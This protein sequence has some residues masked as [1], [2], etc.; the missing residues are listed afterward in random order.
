[1]SGPS[2]ETPLGS[3]RVRLGPHSPTTAFGG[4]IAGGFD[5]AFRL[6]NPSPAIGSGFPEFRYFHLADQ[7]R[8]RFATTGSRSGS[9]VSVGLRLRGHVA[10]ACYRPVRAGMCRLPAGHTFL[11]Q[12]IR[13]PPTNTEARGTAPAQMFAIRLRLLRISL[14]SPP[15]PLRLGLSWLSFSPPSDLP[16]V[17]GVVSPGPACRQTEAPHA[18]RVEGTRLRKPQPHGRDFHPL[19]MP[20]T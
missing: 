19:C 4:T 11:I 6:E 5:S 14:A 9:C 3:R 20:K 17:A 16:I 2:P 18:S 12:R 1:M 8:H 10:R 13:F 15:L 7:T